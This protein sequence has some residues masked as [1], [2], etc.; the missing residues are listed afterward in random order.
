M[1]N[2]TV[3]DH[4]D[5]R[6]FWTTQPSACGSDT[7]CADSCGSPGLQLT[8]SSCGR[9]Q[10]SCCP[11]LTFRAGCGNDGTKN[12]RGI[13]TSNWLR[14]LVINI[15]MTDGRL[16]D[17]ACG[18]RPYARGGHWSDSFRTDGQRSGTLVR[19]LPANVRMND[20]AA[21]AQAQLRADL[22]KLV[23]MQVAVDVAVSVRYI[24]GRRVQADID[25]T[26]AD[27]QRTRVGVVGT[28]VSNTWTW[29]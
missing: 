17:T 4:Q 8:D 10:C 2:C 28:Q 7:R 16:P 6:S 5:R 13:V 9:Y 20:A 23:V 15:L 26:T 25:V 18:Y 22:A 27:Q 29:S 14:G 12:P 11:P 19:T 1:M 21:V 24:G 3:T